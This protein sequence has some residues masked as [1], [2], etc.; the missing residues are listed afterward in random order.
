MTVPQSQDVSAF[1]RRGALQ[2]A[3]AAVLCPLLASGPHGRASRRCGGQPRLRHSAEGSEPR[4]QFVP[5]GPSCWEPR[6]DPLSGRGRRAGGGGRPAPGRRQVTESGAPAPAARAVSR[7]SAA[8]SQD[9]SGLP[10]PLGA[11]KRPAW[12]PVR[13]T[14]TG[15]PCPPQHVGFQRLNGKRSR[16]F[17]ALFVFNVNLKRSIFRAEFWGAPSD[18]R[19]CWRRRD[20]C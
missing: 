14:L 19:R 13:H 10:P 2:A 17:W 8:H 11:G 7:G 9:D 5:A 15:R 6:A 4:F 20:G 16:K 18:P 3:D 1:G 12:W